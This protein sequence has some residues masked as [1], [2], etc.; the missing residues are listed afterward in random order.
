MDPPNR[1]CYEIWEYN[2]CGWAFAFTDRSQFSFQPIDV[3]VRLPSVVSFG[4]VQLAGDASVDS[5]AECVIQCRV[6]LSVA[7]WR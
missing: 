6:V 4:A 7:S 1:K 3:T 5:R 2:H